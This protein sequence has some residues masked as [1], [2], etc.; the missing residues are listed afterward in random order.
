MEKTIDS[1]VELRVAIIVRDNYKDNK[2]IIFGTMIDISYKT[3]VIHNQS[4]NQYV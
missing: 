2:K 1:N 4:F 3:F